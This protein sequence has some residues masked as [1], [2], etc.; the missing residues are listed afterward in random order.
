[1]T[2][3]LEAIDVIRNI[4]AALEQRGEEP[5]GDDDE[6]ITKLD[7]WK[8]TAEIREPAGTAGWGASPTI[9]RETVA[10]SGHTVRLQVHFLERLDQLCGELLGAGRE[11]A[12]HTNSESTLHAGID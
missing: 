8:A 1:M 9:T 3:V 7:S 2:S 11:L 12:R 5:S 4:L 10:S 6:L